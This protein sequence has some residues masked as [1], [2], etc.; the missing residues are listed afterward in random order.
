MKTDFFLK[1]ATHW[2]SLVYS[3][4]DS[5]PLSQCERPVTQ[6]LTI[7][8]SRASCDAKKSSFFTGRDSFDLSHSGDEACGI[9][10]AGDTIV[11]T[12]GVCHNYVTRWVGGKIKSFYTTSINRLVCL[13]CSFLILIQ[14]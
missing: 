13:S 2:Q 14:C 7:I 11:L 9:P 10:D 1:K 8:T 12:G 3:P 4:P 5:H 6:S